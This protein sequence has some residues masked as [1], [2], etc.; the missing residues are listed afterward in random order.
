MTAEPTLR[1]LRPVQGP[2]PD[3]TEPVTRPRAMSSV[4]HTTLAA[5]DICSFGR[6]S[7]DHIQLYQRQELYALLAEACEFTQ[8]PWG[9]CYREDR[10]DGTLIIAPSD[11]PAEDLLDPFAHHLTAVLRRHNR[12]TSTA[13]RLQLRL[14][15]HTGQ[16]HR[17]AHGVAGR[18]LVHL[19]RLLE[20]SSFKKALARTAADLGLI[21]S[22]QLYADAGGRS[23][24]FNP[25]AYRPLSIRCKETRT[26]GWA[27]FP[28]DRSL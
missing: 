27:W 1:P 8:I 7:D 4:V 24:L 2:E 23:G 22:E 15:V 21:V 9:D 28:P 19:F 13:A 6:L 3:T 17:D 20:A 12:L 11:M 10:G 14:A 18:A 5:V 25:D 26:R 16:V